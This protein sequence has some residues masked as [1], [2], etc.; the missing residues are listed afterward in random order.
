[1]A[2]P[3]F[4]EAYTKSVLP[5]FLKKKEYGNPME[6]PRIKKVTVNTG[7]GKL[8]GQRTGEELKKIL[9]AVLSDLTQITGQKP[10]LTQARKSVAGFGLRKGA[11]VGCKV[12]LRG[13]RMYDFLERFVRITLPRSRDFRGI[14]P[15]A[16]DKKGNLTIGIPE[17]LVFP[18]ISPEHVKYPFGLEVTVTTRAQNA[19][20]AQEMFGLLGF[21]FAK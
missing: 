12:T 9:D 7:L 3:T 4:Q 16:I 19:E 13:K 14:S 11:S 1:M 20:E 5:F 6:V 8:V 18:E 17:H 10:S 2:V 15:L 21:P